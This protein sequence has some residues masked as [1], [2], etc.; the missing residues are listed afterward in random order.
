MDIRDLALQATFLF[1]FTAISSH[2]FAATTG[3]IARLG[4]EGMDKAVKSAAAAELKLCKEKGQ[5]KDFETLAKWL[6]GDQDG[7]GQIFT[8]I[9]Q[10]VKSGLNAVQ[11]G[12]TSYSFKDLET[13]VLPALMPVNCR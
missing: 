6:V 3:Q 7:L 4:P 2:S 12:A 13:E 11:G 5:K 9:A 1:V 8:A 10:D